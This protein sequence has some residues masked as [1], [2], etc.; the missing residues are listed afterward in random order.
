MNLFWERFM[1]MNAVSLEPF[2][3]TLGY[4]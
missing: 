4:F 3:I 2:V 1:V